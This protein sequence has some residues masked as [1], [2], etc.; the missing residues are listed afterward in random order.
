MYANYSIKGLYIMELNVLIIMIILL[1]LLLLCALFYIVKRYSSNRN[2]PSVENDGLQEISLAS[3]CS[4]Q[5]HCS[6][7]SDQKGE[8]VSSESKDV[9]GRQKMDNALGGLSGYDDFDMGDNGLQEDSYLMGC[10]S[11]GAIPKTYSSAVVTKNTRDIRKYSSQEISDESSSCESEDVEERQKVSNALGGLSGYDDFG[12]DD[13]GLQRTS[14]FMSYYSLGAIPKIYSSAVMTKN[15]RDI[16]RYSGQEISDESSSCSSI[17][18]DYASTKSSKLPDFDCQSERSSSYDKVVKWQAYDCGL[19]PI[20]RSNAAQGMRIRLDSLGRENDNLMSYKFGPLLR[21]SSKLV[22]S[23]SDSSFSEFVVNPTMCAELTSMTPFR[24]SYSGDILRE[25][26]KLPTPG[27]CNVMGYIGTNSLALQ[28]IVLDLRPC[29]ELEENLVFVVN[30]GDL[31]DMKNQIPSVSHSDVNSGVFSSREIASAMEGECEQESLRDVVQRSGITHSESSVVTTVRQDMDTTCEGGAQIVKGITKCLPDLCLEETTDS[32]QVQ[33]ILIHSD[34]SPTIVPVCQE[35]KNG[36]KLLVGKGACF[37]SK[38]TPISR[39]TMMAQPKI[40]DPSISDSI[41][42]KSGIPV[43]VG[44]SS[45]I[46]E[47]KSSIKNTFYSGCSNLAAHERPKNMHSRL[48]KSYEF[49]D[50]DPTV[51]VTAK[52]SASKS[53]QPSIEKNLRVPE[54]PSVLLKCKDSSNSGAD[55]TKCPIENGSNIAGIRHKYDDASYK[56][57][58]SVVRK[59]ASAIHEQDSK[60]ALE[61]VAGMVDHASI[62]KRSAATKN[63]VGVRKNKG[64]A[65]DIECK[66]WNK[67]WLED[68]FIISPEVTIGQVL[69]CGIGVLRDVLNK[70]FSIM[71]KSL[72]KY[73]RN[74]N[75]AIRCREVNCIAGL[76]IRHADNIVRNVVREWVLMQ[77]AML[78]KKHGKRIVVSS[79]R[80]LEKIFQ[81]VYVDQNK[82]SVDYQLKLRDI[83]N[84]VADNVK[85][86]IACLVRDTFLNNACDRVLSDIAFIIFDKVSVTHGLI[87]EG[88]GKCSKEEL[89]DKVVK[90]CSLFHKNKLQA[91]VL[92]HIEDLKVFFEKHLH[93]KSK[94]VI[95]KSLKTCKVDI[96]HDYV[97]HC[98]VDTIIKATTPSTATECTSDM[99]RSGMSINKPDEQ[100]LS[101]G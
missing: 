84:N 38:K 4:F 79:M 5:E 56:G 65:A 35:G 94:E 57:H 62:N 73:N 96:I 95:R 54:K 40:R 61:C 32:E 46:V 59:N 70:Q 19:N 42:R 71:Y 58:D 8:N 64:N 30:Q 55:P 2:I 52:I 77:K 31:M 97:K 67:C 33:S 98:C 90:S 68:G 87:I 6:I 24:F 91:K 72:S 51:E 18:D 88:I 10:Y 43:K 81:R 12:I 13:N 37:Q 26:G 101:F 23:N 36:S 44:E 41:V 45:G 82:A 11:S 49:K 1:L 34:T 15:T 83:R 76:R 14:Y 28:S 21:S 93:L 3:S 17:L 86:Q 85:L 22:L 7:P 66:V 27:F 75:A 53:D 89:E 60:A 69:I 29:E 9:K 100:R 50:V 78:W 63:Y 48:S 20:C 16:R 80:D 92:T 25:V 39:G 47:K 74:S 99:L